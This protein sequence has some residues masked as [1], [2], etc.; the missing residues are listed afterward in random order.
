PSLPHSTEPHRPS[1]LPGLPL[2][3]EPYEGSRSFVV[4]A[5]P[6]PVAALFLFR[7]GAGGALL[8]GPRALAARRRVGASATRRAGAEASR[9]TRG[10]EVAGC[11]AA[12][13]ARPAKASGA[14]RR[15]ARSAARA[16]G[17]A[18]R[19]PRTARATGESAR[20]RRSAESAR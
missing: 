19:S 12:A 7:L 15:S 10:P 9:A 16:A 5:V 11:S 17:P 4:V 14:A 20:T 6:P 2:T 1:L 13:G 3:G 18:G 8:F